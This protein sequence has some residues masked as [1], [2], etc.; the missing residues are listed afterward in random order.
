M[1]T[2][3]CERPDCHEDGCCIADGLTILCFYHLALYELAQNPRGTA[4]VVGYLLADIAEKGK[5]EITTDSAAENDILLRELTELEVNA[6]EAQ[7]E[8]NRSRKTG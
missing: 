4:R 6:R 3:K 8:A 2:H 5:L 7:R 1:S